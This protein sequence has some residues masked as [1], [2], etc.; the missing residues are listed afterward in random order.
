MKKVQ[1]NKNLRVGIIFSLL[2]ITS[3]ILSACGGEDDTPTVESND[4]AVANEV[5]NSQD[6]G[7]QAGEN[8]DVL[9][10][11]SSPA[12]FMETSGRVLWVKGYNLYSWQPGVEAEETLV[13]EHIDPEHVHFTEDQQYVLYSLMSEQDRRQIL[14]IEMMHIATGVKTSLTR[15]ESRYARPAP[16]W[17]LQISD[18]E[19]G[20]FLLGTWTG[21]QNSIL[22]NVDKRRFDLE[23]TDGLQAFW[24]ADG[25]LVGMES[26]WDQSTQQAHLSRAWHFDP[27]IGERVDIEN[28]DLASFEND[29]IA[30]MTALAERGFVF[31]AEAQ[32]IL[33]QAEEGMHL[34]INPVDRN[35]SDYC[36][37]WEIRRMDTDQAIYEG[38]DV[39]QI[40]G[41]RQQADGS[42]FF[43]ERVY[44]E[45]DINQPTARLK[46]VTLEGE[47][48]LI[49]ESVDP[50][51]EGFGFN[52]GES[53]SVSPDGRY[54]LWI[55]GGM[56]TGET[57][58]NFTDLTTQTTTT[59]RSETFDIVPDNSA[60]DMA[61]YKAVYWVAV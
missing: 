55:G 34:E 14:D 30:L 22:V 19:N 39:A 3:L 8:I 33:E 58:L 4:T 35:W 23:Q 26:E 41:V 31:G 12:S 15:L 13:A 38:L 60:A 45:C 9:A 25:T 28:L 50:G 2:I 53:Y 44:A 21:Q 27:A 29:A 32:S 57:T 42:Y 1:K 5:E 20:W 7:S 6:S 46:H 36:N 56:I 54:V 59:V 37:T 48:T 11:D 43:G 18:M 16:D 61:R 24:L 51:G 40:G 10:S 52:E 49:A 17:W 47:V